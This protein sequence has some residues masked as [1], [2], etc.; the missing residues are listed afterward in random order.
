MECNRLAVHTQ[1]QNNNV[2]VNLIL[3]F[4]K[5]ARVAKIDSCPFVCARPLNVVGWTPIGFTKVGKPFKYEDQ[6]PFPAQ[7]LETTLFDLC[8][9]MLGKEI[10]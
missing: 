1:H 4:L 5:W 8:N 9:H 2:G 6:D 7:V 3:R 10:K